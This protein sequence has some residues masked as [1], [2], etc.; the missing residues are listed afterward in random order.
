MELIHEKNRIVVYGRRREVLAE[1]I[2]EETEA[3]VV[4]ISHTFVDASLRGQG[5]AGRLMEEAV[6]RIRA[7][8]KR[9]RA[10]CSYADAWMKK[11]P[12]EADLLEIP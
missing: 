12:E 1:I 6:R 10:S 8:G 4:T 3:R 9:L 2:M 11:H 7:E 5:V